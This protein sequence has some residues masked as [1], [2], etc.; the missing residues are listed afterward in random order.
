MIQEC[1]CWLRGLIEGDGYTDERH[2]EIFN[3]SE[4]I[5]T[6]TINDLKRLIPIARIKVDIY[7]EF[8]NKNMILK[9]SNSLKLP[10]ENFKLRKNTSPW[11]SRTEKIR[12]RISSKELVNRISTKPRHPELYVKGLFD[13]EASVDIKGYVEFKQL[14]SDKGTLLV[15]NTFNILRNLGIDSTEV[16]TKNDR[17]IK[18]DVY[19][20]VKDLKKFQNKIGFVD[21]GKKNKL[22]NLILIK[23]ENSNPDA[24]QIKKLVNENNSMWD[25]MIELKSPYHKVRKV[26]KDDHL[27][28]RQTR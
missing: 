6:K 11:K 13:A 10:N 22:M 17:N 12:I 16:K 14:A 21:I 3:S 18:R 8:P 20:Y 26:L 25:I 1:N 27:T 4:S 19:F 15:N 7:S 23:E 28:V 9:W 24:E 5:L 2:I